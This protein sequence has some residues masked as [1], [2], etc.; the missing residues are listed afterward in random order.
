MQYLLTQEEY[1]AV[2]AKVK[3]EYETKISSFFRELEVQLNEDVKVVMPGPV[4]YKAISLDKLRQ[5]FPYLDRSSSSLREI[6]LRFEE[7]RNCVVKA[8]DKA[9][10]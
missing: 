6:Y 9:G 4:P 7:V 1:D 3:C 2:A 5:D 10:L 8:K